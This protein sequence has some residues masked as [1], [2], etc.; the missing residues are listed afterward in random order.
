MNT[1]EKGDLFENLSYNIINDNLSQGK[2][3][4][5]PAYC[6]VFQKKGYYSA[7]RLSDIIFDIS[8]EV[9]LPGADTYSLLYLIECKNYS[10][11][12]PVNKIEDFHSKIQQV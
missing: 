8:I 2:L 1:V 10:T 5:I 6:R 9:W 3:G 12:V 11:N 7:S 4:L